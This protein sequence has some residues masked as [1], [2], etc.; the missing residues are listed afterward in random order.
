[1]IEQPTALD[2]TSVARVIDST[3][4]RSSSDEDSHGGSNEEGE[5]G[6]HFVD[7]ER[8]CGLASGA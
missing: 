5:L 1:M 7:R 8:V 6:E 2:W 4:G 3:I